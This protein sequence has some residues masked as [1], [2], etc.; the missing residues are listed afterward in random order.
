MVVD[1]LPQALCSPAYF[2]AQLLHFL[3]RQPLSKHHPIQTAKSKGTNRMLQ[4]GTGSATQI[5]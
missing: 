5:T 2:H 3:L 1:K 4:Q